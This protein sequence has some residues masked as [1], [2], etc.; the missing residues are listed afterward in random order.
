MRTGGD[1]G[2]NEQTS[3]E[4]T[5][6]LPAQKGSCTELSSQASPSLSA[7]VVVSLFVFSNK[8]LGVLCSPSGR[9]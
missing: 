9:K 6:L 3:A 5:G 1:P 8:P 2:S 7:V 4:S